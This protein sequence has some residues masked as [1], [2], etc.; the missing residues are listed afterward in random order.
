SMR[1]GAACAQL[2]VS[3]ET[4]YW[5]AAPAASQS[6][7]LSP[8]VTDLDA[9]SVMALTELTVVKSSVSPALIVGFEPLVPATVK[10]PP[11]PPA[12]LAH[13]TPLACVESVWRQSPL[14]PAASL[15]HAGVEFATTRSPL[16]GVPASVSPCAVDSRLCAAGAKVDGT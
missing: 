14:A 9:R 10:A 8:S 11:P 16:T 12:Q 5:S 6:G 7:D 1:M 15:A 2:T 13:L 4:S 3:V